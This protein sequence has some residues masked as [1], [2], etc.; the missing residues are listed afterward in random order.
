MTRRLI[1]LILATLATLILVE[2]AQGGLLP[3]QVSVT[4]QGTQY[5]WTYA[6]VLPTN[7][8]LQSG[9][10]F[11]IYD[12]GGYV[13]DSNVQPDNWAFS[14]ANIGT[15]PDRLHPDDNPALPNLT[16][17]YKGDTLDSG[18]I[19]LGNFW[20]V[21]E[22]GEATDSFFTARTHR[23]SDGRVDSNLTETVVP[24]PTGPQPT[25]PEPT[26][27]VLAGLGLPVLGFLRLRRNQPS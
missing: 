9:D 1:S 20:A 11:T 12:F 19:G 7:M 21:S 16:W 4:P 15:T 8:K 26:T 17:I 5:R 14:S 2:P 27:L 24:V 10:Y 13:P 23:A 6:I 25:I 22:F 3:I 18:Q